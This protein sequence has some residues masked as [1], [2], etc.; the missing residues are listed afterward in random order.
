MKT[1]KILFSA[2]TVLFFGISTT[3]CED[4]LKTESKTVMYES[5][6]SLSQQTDTVYSVLGIIKQMQKIADRTVLLGETRA[7]LVEVTDHVNADLL[8]IANFDEITEDNRYNSIVDYYAIINNCNYFLAKADT[9]L[10]INERKIFEKEYAAVLGFRA[11][12]YLQMAQIYGKV[13]FVT[14]PITSG[15]Q[16]KLENYPLC[17][18]KQLATALKE[19]LVPYINVDEPVYGGLNISTD[20][21][22]IPIRLILA[23]LCLWAEDYNDAALY[24]HE[25]LSSLSLSHAETTGLEFISWSSQDYLESDVRDQYASLFGDTESNPQIITFIP[26][27][28]EV[29]D[30]IVSELDDV[31]ES[32]LD[33]YYFPQLTYSNAIA[34]L[35]AAQWYCY[36]EVNR[37]TG[38]SSYIYPKDVV[39]QDSRLLAGDLR[40]F[41]NIKIRET[42]LDETMGRYN[43]EFQSLNKLY[44][45]KVC[46][47]RKDVVYLRLAEAMN[48]AGL[49]QTA[50]A[51]LK[52]GLCKENIE[53]FVSQAEKDFAMQQG[54]SELYEYSEINF[55]KGVYDFSQSSG[56][57]DY[58]SGNTIGIHSRGSGDAAVNERYELP[59]TASADFV[60][61]DSI[62]KQNL[63]IEKVEEMIA[64]EMALETC[65]EGYRYGDLM[66]ISMHRAE[67]GEY[68]DNEYLATKI[69]DRTGVRDAEL[70]SKLYGDGY[71][72]NREWFI[73]LPN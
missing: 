13:P 40:L 38:I 63:L 67:D 62:G 37:N 17:D 68:A 6:N 39:D 9:S 60:G 30:G 12:T 45:E 19:D 10:T 11:W 51:V 27:E 73:P 54:L 22:F 61:L 26:M 42:D 53:K 58:V 57:P 50:F 4:I 44:D 31:F 43:N 66:R 32:T 49:P 16:A 71:S 25:Y 33:N 52:Y 47:Y 56:R 35:S 21:F 14:E 29:Y 65:F 72:Y 8:A 3:S 24:Y 46:I 5:E 1:R 69:A 70:Y 55:I 18:I 28:E 64:D 15:D 7:D 20:G 36:H 23:D 34:N 41:S 2:L 48:R 59:D